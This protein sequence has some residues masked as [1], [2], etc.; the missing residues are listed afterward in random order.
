MDVVSTQVALSNPGWCRLASVAKVQ[1]SSS[2]SLQV[3]V[4]QEHAP[5]PCQYHK[6]P[7]LA[8][9]LL[10]QDNNMR[11][12][13]LESPL[14][15]YSLHLQDNGLGPQKFTMLN[16]NNHHYRGLRLPQ[17]LCLVFDVHYLI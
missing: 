9:K 17:T 14:E 7:T 11:S 8:A 1:T 16:N 10:I 5:R 12:R 3:Q 15:A 6:P 13:A 4:L 2:N